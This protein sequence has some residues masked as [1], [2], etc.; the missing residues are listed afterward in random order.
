MKIFLGA[1]H[2]G[3]ELKE[4]IAKW[5]FEMEYPYQDLGANHL[6][7]NDDFT[8]Y[9]ED[10]ASLVAKTD[11]AR[12]VLLCGSGVGVDVLANKFD[13]IRSSIGKDVFQVEAGRNDDDMNILVI[14][15]DFT[16][17]KEAKAMLIAFLETKFSGKA[18]YE[19]RLQEIKEIE[20]NN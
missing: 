14:A 2:R 17:E 10:V 1:D 5:L 12:G 11:G 19:R 20:A 16:E 9:A 8:K 15:A 6:D 4:K 13:G 3:Y 7:P 18:R